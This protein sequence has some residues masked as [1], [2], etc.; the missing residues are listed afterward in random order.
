VS[1]LAVPWVQSRSTASIVATNRA[2]LVSR[3]TSNA[4]NSYGSHA[5]ANPTS[6]L[7]PLSASTC[8]VCAA[9]CTGWWNEAWMPPVISLIRSVREATA[10]RNVSGLG[11]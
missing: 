8:A 6:S 1:S 7:P 4:S 5:R 11:Q 10:A 9:S 2:L 3:S